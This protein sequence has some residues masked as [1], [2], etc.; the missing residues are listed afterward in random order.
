MFNPFKL[1][2]FKNK[3]NTDQKTQKIDKETNDKIDELNKIES[4]SNF[5]NSCDFNNSLGLNAIYYNKDMFLKDTVNVITGECEFTSGV[6]KP[7]GFAKDLNPVSLKTK[8]IEQNLAFEVPL[9]N[10]DLKVINGHVVIVLT[11]NEHTHVFRCENTKEGRD[12]L[13][14]LFDIIINNESVDTTAN[15]AKDDPS[16][17]G[18]TDATLLFLQLKN[19]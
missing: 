11:K 9:I 15:P 13:L 14:S 8:P 2:G 16:E 18:W 6:K 12:S 5:D 7:V 19:L 17:I 3:Q 10:Y 4:L 1:F